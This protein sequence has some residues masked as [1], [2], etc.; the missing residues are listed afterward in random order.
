MRI[1]DSSVCLRTFTIRVALFAATLLVATCGCDHPVTQA[2]HPANIAHELRPH[3]LWRKNRNRPLS[4]NAYFS[5][6][7]SA[8]DQLGRSG[9]EQ[10]V[11]DRHAE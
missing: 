10:L 4:E 2:L 6:G 9:S 11:G 1:H 8:R 3:R 5:V 7:P